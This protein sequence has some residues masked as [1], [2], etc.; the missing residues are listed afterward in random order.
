MLRLREVT[1][2]VAPHP[3]LVEEDVAVVA[4]VHAGRIRLERLLG[5]DDEGQRLILD[6]DQFGRVLGDGARVGADGSYPLA[7]VA[8][9]GVRER[10]AL[11]ARNV[12][13]R[14]KR[15]GVLEQLLAGQ[16]VMDAGHRQRRA[17]VDLL[18][19]RG[20]IRARNHGDVLHT[21]KAHVGGI[22]SAA[23]DE[24]AV[25]LHAALLRDVFEVPWGVAHAFH[26]SASRIDFAAICTAS[27]ICT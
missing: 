18:D 20:G 24:A 5:V 2:D 10:R 19:Q 17:C 23:R 15:I 8:G 25:F 6:F 11:H 7:G 1:L 4:L 21:G 14:E 9:L 27:T 3:F 22:A 13:A 26:H 16:H 12:D